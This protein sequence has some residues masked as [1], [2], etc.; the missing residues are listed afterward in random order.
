[1]CD[2]IDIGNNKNNKHLHYKNKYPKNQ[3]FWGLGIENELYLE[4]T[5]KVSIN[6]DNFIKNHSK[7]RYSID[8]YTNY[9]KQALEIAFN[10]LYNNLDKNY[11]SVVLINSHSFTKTDSD[12]NPKTTYSK[13]PKPNIKFNGKTLLENLYES[14]EYFKNT[15]GTVWIFDGDTI[16]FVTQNFANVKLNNILE[17]LDTNKSEFENKLQSNFEKLDLFKFNGKIKLMDNNHPWAIYMTNLNNIAMFNNG[18]LHYNITLPTLLDDESN[19][20]DKD[21]FIA[22]HKKGIIII[23]WMEPFLIA[24]YGT[25]D[26]FYKIENLSNKNTFSACSQR[27]AISRYIGIGTFEIGRAHV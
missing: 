6:K 3:L 9:K 11:E 22:N 2:I 5:N 25:P 8:Y 20:I 4:F 7:E 23:Q 26:P 14:D 13:N 19:I 12:N 24:I 1:M 21:E 18:T 16:E 10:C 17:E 27:C 15:E